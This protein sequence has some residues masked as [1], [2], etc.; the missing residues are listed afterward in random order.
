MPPKDG[1]AFNQPRRGGA[2]PGAGRKP[3]EGGRVHLSFDVPALLK[4][5]LDAAASAVGMSRAQFLRHLVEQN[6]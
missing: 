5:R 3:L 1:V 6:V 2:R 4:D